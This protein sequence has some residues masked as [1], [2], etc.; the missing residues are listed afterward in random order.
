[1]K[2]HEGAHGAGYRKAAAIVAGLHGLR[3]ASCESALETASKGRQYH[4]EQSLTGA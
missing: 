4:A 1:M 2:S 3:P